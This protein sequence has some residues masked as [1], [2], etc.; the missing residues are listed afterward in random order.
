MLQDKIMNAIGFDPVVITGP[1]VIP[2]NEKDARVD[3]AVFF[4]TA[5][6]RLYITRPTTGD[7]T[8]ESFMPDDI[9]S[10]TKKWKDKE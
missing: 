8:S 10:Q 6:R 3:E 2:Q 9:A 5:N 1:K 7:S 4:D